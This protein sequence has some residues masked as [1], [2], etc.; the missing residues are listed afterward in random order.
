MTIS[1]YLCA[2]GVS[3][4]SDLAILPLIQ[5]GEV[6]S[7]KLA[8]TGVTD[9]SLQQLSHH[10]HQQVVTLN[11]LCECRLLLHIFIKKKYMRY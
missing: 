4:I 9:L 7:L 10:C 11:Q 3:F 2:A 1:K 8:G 6:E 5:G